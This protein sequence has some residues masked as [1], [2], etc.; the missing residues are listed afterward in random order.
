M[1]LQSPNPD[2]FTHTEDTQ[3]HQM[4]FGVMTEG[5]Q[6]ISIPLEVVAR[7]KQDSREHLKWL[8]TPTLGQ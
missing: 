3:K 1:I 7:V 5:F 6:E 2:P 4:G 8:Q